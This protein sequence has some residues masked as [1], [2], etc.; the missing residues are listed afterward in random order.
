[1]GIYNL[2]R[3]GLDSATQ[4]CYNRFYPFGRKWFYP[5]AVFQIKNKNKKL[6]LILAMGTPPC[7]SLISLRSHVRTKEEEVGTATFL[8]I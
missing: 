2:G 1:M 8:I 4:D 3:N 5:R 6:V 7:T